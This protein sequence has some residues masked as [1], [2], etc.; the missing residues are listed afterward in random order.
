M[1]RIVVMGPPGSGKSRLA[2]Q[3][4]ERLGLPVFHL[5]RFYWRPG[6]V[7]APTVEFRAE[8][9]RLAALPGWVIDGNYTGTLEMRL[10]RAD[11][12]VFLDVPSSLSLLRVLRRCLQ[13]YGTVR[14][15]VAPGCAERL[16]P[17]F[18]LFTWRWNHRQRARN[19]A[20]LEGFRGP[21]T[22]LRGRGAVR[23]YLAGLRRSA[24]EGG[25]TGADAGAARPGEWTTGG[26]G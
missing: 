17:G 21:V 13:G 9:E 19:L 11:A 24:G 16:D 6:W 1:R 25:V 15:D 20:M 23:N 3:L 5:D 12:V 8:V 2:R 14:A 4:G 10:R 7:E 22:V 18:L 26:A